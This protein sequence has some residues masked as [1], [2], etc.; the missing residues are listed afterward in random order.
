MSHQLAQN[1]A[2]YNSDDLDEE[3]VE[4]APGP[5][6]KKPKLSKAAEAK[7]KAKAKAAAKA[8]AK[9]GGDNDDYNGSTDEDEEAYNAPSK[10]FFRTGAAAAKPSNGSFEK[11]ARCTQQF[12][13]VRT[14]L[15]MLVS[16]NTHL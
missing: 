4:A 8:K 14:V 9:K 13:V 16:G 7:A 5:S 11:C 1:D 3:D 15:V 12:T 10:S 2:E 6:R